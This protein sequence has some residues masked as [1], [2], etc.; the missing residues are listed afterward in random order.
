M[1]PIKK[2]GLILVLSAVAGF[3]VTHT[4]RPRGEAFEQHADALWVFRTESL[5]ELSEHADAIVVAEALAT[6][7]GRIAFSDDGQEH[8]PFQL[9]EFTVRDAI[10]GATTG[11]RLFVERVG[12]M[13]LD[14]AYVD[15]ELDGGGYVDGRT[16]VLFLG[17][18][19][20]DGI[21]YVINGEARYDVNPRTGLL[22][23]SGEMES[24][25]STLVGVNAAGAA[26]R[27]REA[28]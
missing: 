15:F 12:G 21:H 14:G 23:T 2:N 7:P 16:Y 4:V 19:P 18:K 11:D 20:E 3:M 13:D 24:L 9:V 28:L 1:S 10:K 6:H 25:T 8:L 27:I 26:Q 5:Q 17:R 22:S